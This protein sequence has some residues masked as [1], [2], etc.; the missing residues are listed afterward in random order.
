MRFDPGLIVTSRINGAEILITGA[1]EKTSFKGVCIF[2]GNEDVFNKEGLYFSWSK[3]CF[4]KYREATPN[5]LL[6]SIP[7]IKNE[8]EREVLKKILKERL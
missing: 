4:N 2:R 7:R 3:K 8:E 6:K 5:E 1:T